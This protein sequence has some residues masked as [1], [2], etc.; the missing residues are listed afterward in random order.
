MLRDQVMVLELISFYRNAQG[1]EAQ[2]IGVLSKEKG[3]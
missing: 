3:G 2:A 1:T